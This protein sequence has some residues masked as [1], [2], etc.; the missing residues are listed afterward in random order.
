L[1]YVR[2]RLSPLGAVAQELKELSMPFQV[3]DENGH[4]FGAPV[5]LR[6][7]ILTDY[8]G[9]TDLWLVI[10]AFPLWPWAYLAEGREWT[11]KMQRIGLPWAWAGLAHARKAVRRR[12]PKRR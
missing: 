2:S 6:T 4:T 12:R 8:G 10:K 1:S 11:G 3:M 7:P 9:R 5:C